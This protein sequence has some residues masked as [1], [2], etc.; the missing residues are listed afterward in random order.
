MTAAAFMAEFNARFAC[1]VSLRG[2]REFD[3]MG[4][5]H[6]PGSSCAACFGC[7]SRSGNMGVADAG[8]SLHRK[9]G[10]IQLSWACPG[11]GKSVTEETTL[12]AATADANAIATDPLC[13]R[14]RSGKEVVR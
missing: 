13:Y 8:F 5:F 7:D 11:C 12:M 9:D 4:Q 6:P 10:R 3:Q 1:S 14:C 2:G